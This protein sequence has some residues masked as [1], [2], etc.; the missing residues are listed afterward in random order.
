MDGAVPMSHLPWSLRTWRATANAMLDLVYGVVAGVLLW[1]G[2]SVGLSLLVIAV[3]VLVV[4]A[5]LWLARR[6]SAVYRSQL[7]GVL[8]VAIEGRASELDRTAGYWARTWSLL[9]SPGAW[10]DCSHGLLML[11]LG[12]L[13]FTVVVTAWSVA[14]ALLGYPAY[15][16]LLPDRSAAV[17]YWPGS[18]D[19]RSLGARLLVALVGAGMLFVAAWLAGLTASADVAL[20]RALLGPTEADALRARVATLTT[21]RAAVVDAADEERRRI[22][23]DLHDGVQPMLVSLAMNLGLA[24]RKIGDDPAAALALIQQA[25]EESKKAIAD[26]RNVIRGVHPAVLTERGLDPAL[27]A[28]A[29]RSPVPVTVDSDPA[30]AARRFDPTIEAVAYFVV[31]EALTNVARHARAR[32]ASVVVRLVPPDRV[33]VVVRDDGVGGATPAPGSGLAGLMDRVAAVDGTLT[34]SSPDNGGTTVTLELPCA[35]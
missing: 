7:S 23:R 14:F 9:R 29:A 10:K 12:P 19:A 27:S 13:W 22:E 24:Q 28:L 26:L 16:G 6:L 33:V 35:S 4:A 21:T 25:H 17:R 31:A 8:G 2:L 30:L 34:V 3:G 20:A 5:T 1:T 15:A 32:A 11:V 18:L